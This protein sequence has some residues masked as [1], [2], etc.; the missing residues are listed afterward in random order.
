[1]PESLDRTK[2]LAFLRIDDET[3]ALLRGFRPLLEKSIPAILDA[4][5]A[6]V[7]KEDS[8]RRM[9]ADEAHVRH[10][11]A[12]QAQGD[13]ERRDNWLG[14][15]YDQDPK[16]AAASMTSTFNQSSGSAR[17]IAGSGWS[18]VGISVATAW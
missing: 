6:H 17:R 9:F 10:A 1:M 14:M 5:Y 12:A 16:A 3:R 13:R 8:L 2:K 18:R 4:F 7:T 11:R 15:A